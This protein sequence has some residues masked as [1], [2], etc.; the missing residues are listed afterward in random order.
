LSISRSAVERRVL[1]RVFAHVAPGCMY[2]G[3]LRLLLFLH[4]PEFAALICGDQVSLLVIMKS[5][6]FHAGSA[7]LRFLVAF[8]LG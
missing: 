2:C 1:T 8:R 7:L 5:A 3:L 4:G 6:F